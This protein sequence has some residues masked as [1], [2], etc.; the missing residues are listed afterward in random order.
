LND[1]FWLVLT[2]KYQSAGTIIIEY[3]S[4]PFDSFGGERMRFELPFVGNHAFDIRDLLPC[5]DYNGDCW[6]GIF[7]VELELNFQRNTRSL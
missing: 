3:T 2:S 4:T 1:P 7:S 6:T 5:F